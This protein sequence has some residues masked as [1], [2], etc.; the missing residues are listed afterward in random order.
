MK[1]IILFL[2]VIFTC[3][4]KELSVPRLPRSDRYKEDYNLVEYGYAWIDGFE[5][6]NYWSNTTECWDGLTNLT[7]AEMPYYKWKSKLSRWGP[8]DRVEM[9]TG[10]LANASTYFMYC[11][12]ALVS[13]G[14]FWLSRVEAYNVY[15][16]VTG[17]LFLSMAENF[18]GNL[19]TVNQVWSSI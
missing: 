16:H 15:S 1:M 2:L 6:E 14:R 4:A 3:A 12:S 11:D 9:F 13:A 8:Y 17:M 7:L 5:S 19:P 10:L 18:F